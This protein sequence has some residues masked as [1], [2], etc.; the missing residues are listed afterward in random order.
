[1]VDG[2]IAVLPPLTF[3]EV[4]ESFIR[5]IPHL[6]QVQVIEKVTD[7]KY[8]ILAVGVSDVPPKG[9]GRPKKVVPEAA[10]KGRV[11]VKQKVSFA[12]REELVRA[13]GRTV[14][15]KVIDMALVG[16]EEQTIADDSDVNLKVKHVRIIKD[17]LGMEL[18][19]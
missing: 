15:N 5:E 12:K 18:E 13:Y 14:V 11:E 8:K 6:S 9:R 1:M 3:R 19:K 4:P 17:Q 10:D 16:E 7:P 2:T